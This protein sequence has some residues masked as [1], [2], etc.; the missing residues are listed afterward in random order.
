[1]PSPR[2]AFVSLLVAVGLP[3]LACTIAGATVAQAQRGASGGCGSIGGA[4]GN[5]LPSG[6]AALCAQVAELSAQINAMQSND[7]ALQA[8]VAKL[9]GQITTADLVGTY[10]YVGFQNELGRGLPGRPGYVA[11]YVYTGGAVTL[12]ADGTGSATGAQ[13]G[14]SLNFVGCWVPLT[15]RWGHSTL[16]GHIAM[17]W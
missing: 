1:M 10:A 16:R 3:L 9:E 11:S 15:C 14:N 17:A 2:R 12:N 6:V 4:S 5:G 8:R 7:A 13:S